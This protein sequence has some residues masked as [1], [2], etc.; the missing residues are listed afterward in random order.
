MSEATPLAGQLLFAGLPGLD[1][2]DDLA[3]LIRSGRIGGVTL[4]A[5]N[6]GTP[7]ETRRLTAALHGLAPANAPLCIA[8]DQEGGRVQRLRTPWTEFPTP[9]EL[10]RGDDTT[11][12]RATAE[13]IG[14]ELRDAG[15]DLDFAP[16]CDVDSNPDN[17]V[18][19]DRSFARDPGA[20]AAHAAAFIDG[21]QSTGVAACAK[22]FPGHGDTVV[23]SHLALPRVTTPLER[24]R[25]V[26]WPPFEA[27][28]DAG[29][30]SMMTAHV[31]VEPLD[32]E[33]PATLSP[34]ALGAL[35]DELGWEG[36][37]FTD[38][39]EMKAIAD[40]YSPD[41][42][43]DQALGAGADVMLVCSRDDLRD[44][45]LDALESMPAKRLAAPL[46]RVAAFK[47]RW[48]IGARSFARRAG[49]PYDAHRGLA[50][51]VA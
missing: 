28:R 33:R 31:V 6:V 51:P 12:T 27:A 38:D 11:R 23:D 43:V 40:H 39:L 16:C 49:P 17:P 48:L 44:A 26:E 45:V 20:V 13:A 5:R 15:F 34:R 9:R 18:I 10:G 35:R 41:E 22:H 37:V 36:L 25:S 4:F 50:R 46:A 7:G 2:P 21:L 19:G 1:V 29:V 47:Q 32:A 14:I 8:I 30:A 24:L 3:E 42:I